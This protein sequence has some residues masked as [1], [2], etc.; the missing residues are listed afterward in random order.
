[1]RVTLND[2]QQRLEAL[3]VAVTDT[4]TPGRCI[5]TWEEDGAMTDVQCYGWIASDGT[6][7][8][9]GDGASLQDW[10]FDDDTS[11]PHHHGGWYRVRDGRE[12]LV[13]LP[14]EPLTVLE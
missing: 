3:T 4:D 1:M 14:G 5:V 9:A 12:A 7:F 2:P 13:G 6:L 10:V 11:L 8:V